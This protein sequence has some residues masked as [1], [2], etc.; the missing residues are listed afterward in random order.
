MSPMPAGPK[1]ARLLRTATL[2]GDWN[3]GRLN[4]SAQIS[5]SS[6]LASALCLLGVEFV[7][8]VCSTFASISGLLILPKLLS[9]PVRV[10]LVQAAQR[11]RVADPGELRDVEVADG[12]VVGE[13]AVA[14]LRVELELDPDLGQGVLRDLTDL[15]GGL[16]VV[17]ARRGSP[18]ACRPSRG[19]GRSSSSRARR[20][21]AWPSPGRTRR[22]GCCPGSRPGPQ[23]RCGCSASPG[24]STRPCWDTLAMA[25][26]SMP[27][28]TARRNALSA[29]IEPGAPLNVK[30]YQLGLGAR[31]IAMPA[32]LRAMVNSSSE[33]TPVASS[34][35][36]CSAGI[37][38]ASSRTR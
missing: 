32:V 5:L 23:R 24:L 37:R 21:P 10:D 2:P 38:A 20:V 30:W 27:L 11:E 16:R 13:E 36:F 33:A 18:V 9:A 12:D 26:R 4:P 3:S 28:A 1:F 14:G 17:E 29:R 31:R 35:L 8:D 6:S 25:C 7:E 22:P 34:A 19:T 15:P